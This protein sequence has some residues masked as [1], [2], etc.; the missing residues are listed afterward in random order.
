M[1]TIPKGIQAAVHVLIV[2]L[3]AT[4]ELQARQAAGGDTDDGFTAK[5]SLGVAIDTFAAAEHLKYLNPNDQ[6]ARERGIVGF[7]FQKVILANDDLSHR[8]FVYGQTIHGTRTAEVDCKANPNLFVC[9]NNLDLAKLPGAIDPASVGENAIYLL[10]NATSLEGFMGFRYEGVKLYGKAVGY[11]KMQAGFLTVQ[12]AGGSI[13]DLHYIGFGARQNG[14]TLDGS[15]FEIA[16][17]G[18]NDL[19][20]QHRRRRKQIDAELT[21]P[22]RIGAKYVS[23]FIRMV[24]DTDVG[25]GSDS[26]QTYFGLKFDLKNLF[27]QN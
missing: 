26:V 16:P 15:Y 22:L 8:L 2:I 12:G 18:R 17:F 21:G 10:R 14:G 13:K 1:A 3:L 5:L 19:F 27:K 25:Y 6:S 24:V 23:P 20:S 9:K 11:V 7:D 4:I